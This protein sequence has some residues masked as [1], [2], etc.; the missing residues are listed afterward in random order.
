MGGRGDGGNAARIS[1]GGR[2]GEVG[3][4]KQY[5]CRK[6][7]CDKKI[8]V[9]L[10]GKYCFRVWPI[11]EIPEGFDLPQDRIDKAHGVILTYTGNVRATAWK[12][13]KVR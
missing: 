9:H 2:E 8:V 5:T 7:G 12:A 4:S 10:V 6:E 13:M 1:G 11:Y 3:A